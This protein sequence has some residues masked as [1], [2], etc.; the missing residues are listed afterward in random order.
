MNYFYGFTYEFSDGKLS[1]SIVTDEATIKSIPEDR[2]SVGVIPIVVKCVEC[3]EY[4]ILTNKE[5][6]NSYVGKF[7]CPVCKRS[8]DQYDIFLKMS[9][10]A[11]SDMDKDNYKLYRKNK[12]LYSLA[13]DGK[14]M[15][16]FNVNS[17]ALMNAL[18]PDKL[19]V[20]NGA[21]VVKCVHC[22]K[23]MMPS[24]KFEDAVFVCEDCGRTLSQHDVLK[25]IEKNVEMAVKAW[26]ESLP[27]D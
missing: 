22:G 18:M 9:D 26:K 11:A 25:E 16:N 15:N 27:L 3:G 1:D 8:I 21:V 24:G 17:I 20:G 2:Y 14:K 13:F 5:D 23:D 19:A 12:M 6:H 4:M 10:E 7:V